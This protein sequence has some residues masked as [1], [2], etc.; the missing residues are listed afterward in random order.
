MRQE[1]YPVWP[2]FIAGRTSASASS[3]LMRTPISI[4]REFAQRNVH[5]IRCGA[6][7]LGPAELSNIFDFSPKVKPENCV[8][9]A[10]GISTIEK[11]M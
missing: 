8:L 6:D 4:R 10:C 9:V 5:G 2:N 1:R 11:E 7:G 3:G